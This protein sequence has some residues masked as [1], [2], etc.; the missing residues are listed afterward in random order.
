MLFLFEGGCFL[1]YWILWLVA[2]ACFVVFA[3]AALPVMF[4]KLRR[5]SAARSYVKNISWLCLCA[6]VA[7]A[8]VFVLCHTAAVFLVRKGANFSFEASYSDGAV[9]LFSFIA[10]VFAGA[11]CFD[12]GTT[13]L[14][15]AAFADVPV[16][17][18]KFKFDGEKIFS[19]LRLAAL[20]AA[21]VFSAIILTLIFDYVLLHYV[22]F[23]ASKKLILAGVGCE[24]AV[25]IAAGLFKCKK[26]W[27][28]KHILLSVALPLL[29][30]VWAGYYVLL[31]K[32]PSAVTEHVLFWG[33]SGMF[34]LLPTAA[35][36]A[37]IM[38]IGLK[39]RKE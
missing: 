35:V 31:A 23:S 20:S 10:A 29:F 30:A 25:F 15:A 32:F 24:L 21:V 13:V 34:V 37:I 27:K 9:I 22:S 8:D 4:K 11:F 38:R 1:L 36:V 2:G 33:G 16:Y 6:V 7:M 14:Q 12:A 19:A 17:S 5:L 18:R 3:S 39:K 26:V 28:I